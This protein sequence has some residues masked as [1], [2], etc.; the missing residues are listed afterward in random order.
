MS[1]GINNTVQI[2]KESTFNTPV[3][4]TIGMIPD[5]GSDGVVID[6]D[7]Q[8]IEGMKGTAAANKCS[9]V[10]NNKYAGNF[11]A[12]F[13]SHFCSHLLLSSMGTDTPSTVEA[14]TVYKHTFSES[15]SKPS[16]SLQQKFGEIIKRFGGF[17]VKGWTLD[18][19]TGAPVKF[20]FNGLA[21]SQATQSDGSP[22]FET[23]CPLNFAQVTTMTIAT[24]SSPLALAQYLRQITFDYD[25]AIAPFYPL[26]ANDP[27]VFVAGKSK[28]TGKM[29]LRVTTETSAILADNIAGTNREI[30]MEL[31][32]Q[33]IGASSYVKLKVRV[34]AAS[35]KMY[36]T[37]LNDD[38]NLVDVDFEAVEDATN[39]QF[40]VEVTNTLATIS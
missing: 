8:Y 5:Y 7:I 15:A 26:G 28:L 21:A 35:L 34:Y 17:T 39:G 36:K 22:A 25:N 6:P 16:Y 19:K 11:S 4:P 2:G 32:G 9:F 29:T 37:K 20:N 38:I 30:I 14:S 12:N 18:V 23:R 1:T 3:S 24:N 31:T 10:G 33:A 27:V 40:T 13:Y